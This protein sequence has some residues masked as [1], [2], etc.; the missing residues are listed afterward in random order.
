MKTT[1]IILGLSISFFA[2][3]SQQTS[4]LKDPRDG[5]V[6]KTVKIGDKWMMAEN[7]AYKPDNGNY[8]AYGEKQ[9][10]VAKYGYLYDWETAKKNCPSGWHLPSKEEFETLLQNVGGSDSKAY[11]TLV[12]SGNRSFSALFG[13]YR[14]VGGYFYSIGKC[15]IF[16][17]ST[18]YS[19]YDEGDNNAWNLKICSDN[20][21]AYMSSGSHVM[22]CHSVRCFKD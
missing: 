13:G 7:L 19:S 6:Y 16:W 12:Q 20:A 8:C 11:N 22:S 14:A 3:F 5:K 10:N 9:K 17:S 21:Y 1:F 18:Y 15:A 2:I 4:S